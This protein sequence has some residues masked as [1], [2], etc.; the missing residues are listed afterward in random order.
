MWQIAVPRIAFSCDFLMHGILAFAA[1]HL[2]HL[3]PETRARQLIVSSYHQNLSLSGFRAALSSLNQKNADSIMASSVLIALF[4]FASSAMKATNPNETFTLDDVAD[5][6]VLLRGINDT[7]ASGESGRWVSEGALRPMVVDPAVRGEIPEHEKL[8][9]FP[10][11]AEIREL[12]EQRKTEYSAEVAETLLQGLMQLEKTHEVMLWM[13]TVMD[14]GYIMLWPNTIP[15]SFLSLLRKR[16]PLALIILCF[17]CALL[18]YS[19]DRWIWHGWAPRVLD[20]AAQAL[21]PEWQK[22]VDWPRDIVEK[23]IKYARQD[24]PMD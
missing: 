9:F 11:L 21:D 3:Q 10:K 20:L 8:V 4:A 18:H 17:F 14:S 13:D 12:I 6:L 5:L 15:L 24:Y 1:L 23:N 16:H 22:W 19:E 7:L 2:G